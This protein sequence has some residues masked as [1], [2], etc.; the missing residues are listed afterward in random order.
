M[1]VEERLVRYCKVDTQSDPTS[2]TSP[3]TMKQFDLAKILVDDLKQIGLEDVSLSDTCYV[4]AHLPSNTDKPCAKIGFIAHM[5]TAPD[6]SG[7][8]VN[9]RIIENY[10][11]NDI[12]LN[13]TR[14]TKVKDFPQMK[15]FVGK[16]LMVTDGNSLLGADDKAGIVAIIEALDY[17]IQHPEIKHG[18]I[19]VAFTPDEE[20]GRGTEHFDLDLFDAD[21]AYTMDGDVV[22][23]F[24]DETFNAAAATLNITGFSIHPG[25]AKDK[26][27][28]AI[29]VAMEFDA[30]LPRHMRPE[31]TEKKDG[32]YHPTDIVGN[33]ES[34]KLQYIIRDHNK[35]KFIQKQEYMKSCADFIN[36]KYGFDVIDL[37]IKESYR[38][39]KE[40]MDQH[41]EVSRIAKEAIEDLGLEVAEE[42]IRGGT[43]GAMLSFMGLPCPNLGTG[44]GN[45]HG[46]YEYCVLDELEQSVQL[47]LKVVEK[48]ES[49]A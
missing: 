26:L 2:E 13:H 36:Q 6:F 3:S 38:N 46:P 17:L 42:A 33:S 18:Q 7:A 22:N 40:I 39:M 24:A 21:Y 10:D 5:D 32:F 45:F 20:V 43:D 44:G 30:L 47:I 49:E 27:V 9:P 28:N 29:T 41:P 34:L 19:S 8:N 4:Y 25:S 35:E 11:G 23:G 1:S 31:H 37:Q 15:N 14:V 12:Q 16:R 48:V